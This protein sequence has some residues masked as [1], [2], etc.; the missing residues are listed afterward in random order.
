MMWE[1]QSQRRSPNARPP[2]QRFVRSK[3]TGFL[4]RRNTASHR[5][6]YRP[7][8]L[9]SCPPKL[10]WDV[11]VLTSFPKK[12]GTK[13]EAARSGGLHQN[14][15][16]HRRPYVGIIQIRLP[17]EGHTF[18]SACLTSSRLFHCPEVLYPYPARFA[19]VFLIARSAWIP[20][21][22]LGGAARSRAETGCLA[23]TRK[24]WLSASLTAIFP[25]F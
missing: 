24:A 5:C 7:E 12:L 21:R 14:P 25:P 16:W 22:F 4:S 3:L 10:N 23:R 18:L 9:P 17:V 2:P 6:T 1:R 11:P 15:C 13:T 19:R 8:A 20:Q